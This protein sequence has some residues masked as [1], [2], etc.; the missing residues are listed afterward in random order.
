MFAT[1]VGTTALAITVP[2]TNEYWA[3]LMILWFRPKSADIVPNV[4]PVDIMSV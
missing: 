1:T 2:T 4:S 3:W